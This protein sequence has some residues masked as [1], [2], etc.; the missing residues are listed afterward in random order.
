MK[1]R[2]RTRFPLNFRPNGD[3]GILDWY[4]VL[5]DVFALVGSRLP[6]PIRACERS[7]FHRSLS[8]KASAVGE[9]ERRIREQIF[10]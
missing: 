3:E 8:E 6:L 5:I 2:R 1:M 7:V 9:G 10:R 4:T